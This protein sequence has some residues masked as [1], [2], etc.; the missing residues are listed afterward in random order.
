MFPRAD[1]AKNG[2]IAVFHESGIAGGDLTGK[3]LLRRARDDLRAAM[4][5]ELQI[6]ATQMFLDGVFA[7]RERV[8]DLLVREAAA[9]IAD[10]FVF[11]ARE[12]GVGARFELSVVR[13]VQ[14]LEQQL[15]EQ[16]TR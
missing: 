1:D 15:D 14:V 6:S 16:R 4:H 2:E 10:D 5:A 8:A 3:E 13:C 9:H 12:P 7:N 11:A